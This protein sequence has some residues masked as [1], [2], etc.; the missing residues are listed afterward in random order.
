MSN[1]I[2]QV[3]ATRNQSTA[4]ITLEHIFLFGNRYEDGA[5]KNNTGGV[6]VLKPFSLVARNIGTKETASIVFNAT[7]LAAGET[8]IIAGLTYTSTGN[9]TTAQIAAAFADLKEGAV[10]GQQTTLGVYSGI[11]TGYNTGSVAAGT[12]VVFTS[13]VEGNVA[14]LVQTGT[15]AAAAVTVVNGTDAVA[16]GLIPITAD[17]LANAIGISANVEDLSQEAAS[18]DP[19]SYATKGTVAEGLIT[20]PGGVTLNTLVGNKSL[21]D[22]LEDIGFHLEASTENTKFDNN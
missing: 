8:M 3:N 7:Q 19:I 4:L 5:Y 20:L 2:E 12:T 22:I 1:N 18:S 6:V 10:T 14:D 21:R 11:L 16:D 15:G 17:N 9:T 13:V